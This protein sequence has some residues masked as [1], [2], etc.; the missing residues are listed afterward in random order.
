M[1]HQRFCETIL[2]VYILAG[3]VKVVGATTVD[4]R[5]DEGQAKG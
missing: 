4:G 5:Y 1:F 3:D 2:D